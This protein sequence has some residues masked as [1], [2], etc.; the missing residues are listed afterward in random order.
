M[1]VGALSAAPTSAATP[2][3]LS[4]E[5][6]DA[7]GMSDAPEVVKITALRRETKITPAK[8]RF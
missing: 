3:E 5:A 2:I 1:V 4:N 7:L 8:G 6:A